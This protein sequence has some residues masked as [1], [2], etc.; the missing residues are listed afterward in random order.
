LWCKKYFEILKGKYLKHFNSCASILLYLWKM[1]S[2]IF[3][4]S[5]GIFS[6]MQPGKT[7]T[8]ISHSEIHNMGQ[9][10]HYEAYL[11]TLWHFICVLWHVEYIFL[12]GNCA[13][14]L[15]CANFFLKIRERTKKVL[16]MLFMVMHKHLMLWGIIVRYC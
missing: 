11:D 14:C 7:H 1:L 10:H 15:I 12:S 4:S 8:C 16:I 5:Y 6:Q 9:Y 13:I 2:G 3:Q